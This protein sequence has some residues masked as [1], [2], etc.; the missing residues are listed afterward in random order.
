MILRP[1][2][3]IRAFLYLF[4]SYRFRV[5]HIS[6]F[7]DIFPWSFFISLTTFQTLLHRFANHDSSW[8]GILCLF[9]HT[10][11]YR[12]W[13]AF[14]TFCLLLSLLH[15]INVLFLF[16][17]SAIC[18]RYLS[19]RHHFLY[20]TQSQRTWVWYRPSDRWLFTRNR[21]WSGLEWV[22]SLL[23]TGHLSCSL[24]VVDSSLDLFWIVT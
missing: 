2:T 11:L 5:L 1:M 23:S 10:V 14:N 19:C 16:I 13:W 15:Y 6:F 20:G 18:I 9:Y 8:D 12:C 7:S 17:L 21:Y 24:L 22:W 4:F 3:R